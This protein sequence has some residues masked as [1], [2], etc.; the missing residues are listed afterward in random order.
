MVSEGTIASL[1]FCLMRLMDSG[2]PENICE[3]LCQRE[4]KYT[5]R[6]SWSN[7]LICFFVVY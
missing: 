4:V 2:V 5:M 3:K 7:Y 1:G 6:S